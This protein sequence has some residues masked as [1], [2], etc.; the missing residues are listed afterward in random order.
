[1]SM[2]ETTRLESVSS[3]SLEEYVKK[4]SATQLIKE[5]RQELL[6]YAAHQTRASVYPPNIIVTCSDGFKVSLPVTIDAL[7]ATN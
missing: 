4:I 2:G 5:R 7:Y 1:M 3:D 6:E